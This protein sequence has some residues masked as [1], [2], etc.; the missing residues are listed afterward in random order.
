MAP[1]D[2]IMSINDN[3]KNDSD[4]RKVNLSVGA[5]RDNDGKPW[6]LPS[7]R[8]AANRIHGKYNEME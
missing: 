7:V 1:P 8:E 6:I 3:F 2:P 5:Y 4:P